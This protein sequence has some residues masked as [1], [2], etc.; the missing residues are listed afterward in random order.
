MN[1]PITGVVP[2]LVVPLKDGALD[3]PSLERHIERM[4]AAGIHGLFVNG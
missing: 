2:P 3:L 1:T 4:L